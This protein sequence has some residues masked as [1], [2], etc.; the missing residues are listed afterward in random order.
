MLSFTSLIALTI[1]PACAS[2]MEGSTQVVTIDTNPRIQGNCTA[3]NE[4]GEWQLP[5]IPGTIEVKRSKSPMR[6]RCEGMGMKGIYS[7][8]SRTESWGYGNVATVGL[9]AG[10]DG[11]TGALYKYPETITVAMMADSAAAGS[12]PPIAPMQQQGFQPAPTAAF[13]TMPPYTPPPGVPAGGLVPP[14]GLPHLPNQPPLQPMAMPQGLPPIPPQAMPPQGYAPPPYPPAQG[15]APPPGLPMMAHPPQAYA[16]PPQP[17]A[18]QGVPSYPA[19][20]QAI[21]TSTG[22]F[23]PTTVPPVNPKQ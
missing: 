7:A 13:G 11:A 23:V 16:P 6:V 4:R 8:S 22:G 12:T 1:L 9:G 3:T 14:Q 10:V 2:M 19:A 15:I 5:T 20:P 18:P 17:Y 21:G